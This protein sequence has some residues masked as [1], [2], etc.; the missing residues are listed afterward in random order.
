[1]SSNPMDRDSGPAKSTLEQQLTQL[2][3]QHVAV[4]MARENPNCSGKGF[5]DAPFF[6]GG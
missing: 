4:A 2:Q 6:D 3:A 5:P 1:M